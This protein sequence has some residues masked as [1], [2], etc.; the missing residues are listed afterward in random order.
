MTEYETLDLIRSYS[1]SGVYAV[2]NFGVIMF[3]CV[4]AAHLAGKSFSMLSSL[5]WFG[6][7]YYLHEYI[8]GKSD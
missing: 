6:S 3:A 2:M 5:L 4:V 1:D 7:V 8:R